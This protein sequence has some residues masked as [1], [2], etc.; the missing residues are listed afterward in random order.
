M[1]EEK[2]IM[3]F[4]YS[5]NKQIIESLYNKLGLT[6]EF[7]KDSIYLENAFNEI[8]EIWL[9]NF[10]NIDKVKYLMIAEAPLWGQKKKYIYNPKTNNSQFFY[11]SD[12]ESI[13]N[14]QI[15]DKKEFI[16][17][18]NSIGLL[19]VDISPFPLNTVDTKINYGRN[20]NKSKKLTDKEYKEL[21]KETLPT[22]LNKKLILIEQKKSSDIIV[23][24]R[25]TK[26]KETFQELISDTLIQTG[27]IRIPHEI[28]DISQPGGGINRMKL[29]QII[30]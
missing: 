8:N 7:G 4:E 28:A 25:Y 3:V 30:T 12:L 6:K 29:S 1:L 23:F 10:K 2:S 18:C 9:N 24:F 13:L 27:L 17:T 14:V 19:V 20:K 21:V 11:R 22:Y 16:N 26:V 5:E 15:S